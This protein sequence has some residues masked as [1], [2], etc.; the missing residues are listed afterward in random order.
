MSQELLDTIH[1][2]RNLAREVGLEMDNMASAFRRTGNREVSD[3]LHEWAN[4][5]NIA[6]QD[7][8]HAQSRALNQA[9][10]DG[11]ERTALMVT[12]FLESAANQLSN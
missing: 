11:D 10:K 7:V 3:A 6:A 8:V 12:G 1:E 2:M 4:A 5:I 9:V